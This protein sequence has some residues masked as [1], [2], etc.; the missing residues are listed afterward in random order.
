[1]AVH[2]QPG[3]VQ[4]QGAYHHVHHDDPGLR[5][6]QRVPS[7]RRLR[8]LRQ[9]PR[10]PDLAR[11]PVHVPA[12]DAGA[13]LRVRRHVPPVP[14]AAGVLPLARRAADLL[15]DL[16]LPRQELPEQDRQRLEGP[17]HEV[18]LA[19]R[20]DRLV[21]A[22]RPFVPVHVPHHLRLRHLDPPPGRHPESGLRRYVG[23]GLAPP[24]ARLEPN[25]RV[26]GLAAGGSVMGHHQRPRGQ[27][28]LPV[29]RLAG[30]ALEE[31]LVRSV[32]PI[33]V[34]RYI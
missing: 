19:R 21:L 26:P 30:P 2:P 29:G 1:M 3:P 27:C 16:R 25:L 18:L 24:H 22:G 10:D 15:D 31:C 32:L 13:E 14:G 4:L 7:I 9:V 33:L 17:P 23:H 20:A 5:L 8:R 28:L 34:L 6:R 11:L 12:H